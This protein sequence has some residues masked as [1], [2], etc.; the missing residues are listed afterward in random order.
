M[1][2]TVY[3]LP[4]DAGGFVFLDIM[5]YL[6]PGFKLDTFIKSFGGDGDSTDSANSKSYFPYEYIDS[7][8][9]LSETEMPPHDAFYSNVKQENVLDADTACLHLAHASIQVC[10]VHKLGLT[11]GTHLTD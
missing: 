3:G 8:E 10:I 11:R 5:Q 7:Y 2:L 6:A 9:K 1:S 4:H